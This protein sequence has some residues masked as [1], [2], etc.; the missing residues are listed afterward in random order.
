MTSTIYTYDLGPTPVEVDRLEFQ[1]RAV[2]KPLT[3]GLLPTNIRQY[4][5]SLGRAPAVADIATGT[6]VWLSDLA[7][8]LP[9]DARL[10]GYDIEPAKFPDVSQL[11]PNV[12]LSGCDVLVPFPESLHGQYDLVHVRLLI[13]A[14][15]VEQWPTVAANLRS[16]LRPGG[17]L[18][19]AES[20]Y[21]SI[22]CLPMTEHFQKLINAEVRY[23]AAVGRDI[24]LVHSP[25]PFP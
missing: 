25:S 4:L 15:N 6:G 7:T 2:F 13:T 9:S 8:E 21:P 19:W 20:G 1:H 16:L 12:K 10:D 11:P 5:A 22:S 24:M 3:D 14:L 18:F 17:Y 23:A